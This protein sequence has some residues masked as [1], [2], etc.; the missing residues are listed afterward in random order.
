MDE[1]IAGTGNDAQAVEQPACEGAALPGA[2]TTV[3]LVEGNEPH[4]DLEVPLY[5]LLTRTVPIRAHSD[6]RGH[7]SAAGLLPTGPSLGSAGAARRGFEGGRGALQYGRL[8]RAGA[9]CA[10]RLSMA[11]RQRRPVPRGYTRRLEAVE[12]T[13]EVPSIPHDE[14]NSRCGAS[15]G[16]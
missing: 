12:V 5:G 15:A 7:T 1:K 11:G 16:V 8:E 10:K 13:S 14:P 9:A 6:R 3:G 2:T 4:T